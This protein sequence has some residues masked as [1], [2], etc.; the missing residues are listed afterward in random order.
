M[1]AIYL[2]DVAI[3]RCITVLKHLQ[4]KLMI[5]IITVKIHDN[6]IKYIKIRFIKNNKLKIFVNIQTK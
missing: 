3:H 5:I 2:A 4:I 6:D 1:C